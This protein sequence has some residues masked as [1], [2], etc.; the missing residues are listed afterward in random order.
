[1]SAPGIHVIEPVPFRLDRKD[2]LRLLGY[3]PRARSPAPR[4]Q[5]ILDGWLR[6]SEELI[7]SRGAY[8]FGEPGRI[9][10]PAAFRG[11]ELVAFGVCTIG[12]RLTERVT[13]LAARGE[14][15]RAMILDAIGSSAVE[16]ATDVVNAAICE[17]IARRRMI[18]GRRI[19]PGYAAWAIE[20]Q[21]EI[22]SLLPWHVTGVT[23]KPSGF[24]EPRKSVSFAVSA[25][26][27][28]RHSKVVSICAYCSLRRCRYRRQPRSSQQ[29]RPHAG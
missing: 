24:M 21:K 9:Q 6:E 28:I 7:E 25:G 17:S 29:S 12:A 16:S 20:G 27:N 23:L 11:A 10:G 4:V 18:A 15:L 13:E 5:E 14:T 26:R 3:G 2:V 1:M 22:F 19:S 8:A